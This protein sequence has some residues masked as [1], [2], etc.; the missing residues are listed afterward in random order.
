MYDSVARRPVDCFRRLVPIAAVA[1]SA[2]YAH[3]Q[4]GPKAMPVFANGMAQVVPAFEDSTSWIRQEL[5]VETN[6]DSDRDG[7]MD[8]VHVDVTR[9][10]QTDTEGLKVPVIYGSSP[11]YAGTA[12]GQV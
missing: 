9:P 6:F 2:S 12:R 10:R 1:L 4:A 8:R 5:W 11:Y 3:A 7:K